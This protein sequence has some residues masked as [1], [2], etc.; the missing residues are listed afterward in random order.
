MQL[1]T[2]AMRIRFMVRMLIKIFF[3]S[4]FLTILDFITFG[5]QVFL[6]LRYISMSYFRLN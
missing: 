5:H 3:I 2:D 1:K 4:H 6:I